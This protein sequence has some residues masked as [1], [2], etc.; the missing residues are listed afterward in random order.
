MEKI[1]KCILED[2][3]G[4]WLYVGFSQDEIDVIENWKKSTPRGSSDVEGALSGAEV[5]LG[6]AGEYACGKCFDG[7]GGKFV[8]AKDC[9]TADKN[10][11]DK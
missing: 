8:F 11:T 2:V 5:C 7:D 6:V 10:R 9:I 3:D 4:H 1:S